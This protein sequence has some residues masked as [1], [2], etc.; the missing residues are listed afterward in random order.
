MVWFLA[1]S[2]DLGIVTSYF[3]CWQQQ[4]AARQISAS[5]TTKYNTC[6]LVKWVNTRSCWC[7]T[8]IWNCYFLVLTPKL[9]LNSHKLLHKGGWM[10]SC[11]GNRLLQTEG[12]LL[13]ATC[14]EG[15]GKAVWTAHCRQGHVGCCV[16]SCLLAAL[17]GCL[18]VISIDFCYYRYVGQ[19]CTF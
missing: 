7:I 12:L 14:C 2:H 8:C 5:E 19:S 11:T 3:R 10:A 9:P 18:K 17:G 1:Q 13:V 16:G 15:Q 4:Y 6:T